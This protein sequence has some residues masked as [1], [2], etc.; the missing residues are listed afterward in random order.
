MSNTLLY[1]L[2]VLIWGGDMVSAKNSQDGVPV[3]EANILGMAYGG[4]FSF[5]LALTIDFPI[6]FEATYSSDQVR[7]DTRWYGFKIL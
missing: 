6:T 4:V 1:T 5:I 7:K 2:P 3:L